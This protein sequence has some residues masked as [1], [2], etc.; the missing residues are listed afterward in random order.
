MDEKT[1]VTPDADEPMSAPEPQA[2]VWPIEPMP[3]PA[4]FDVVAQEVDGKP[5]VVIATYTPSG[6]SFGWVNRENALA[7]ASQIKKIAGTGPVR[8]EAPKKSGLIVPGGKNKKN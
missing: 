8:Q 7:L 3:L 4:V 1:N 5:I 2:M 6:A